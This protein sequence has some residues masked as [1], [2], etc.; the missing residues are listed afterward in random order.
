MHRPGPRRS[1]S[2]AA[3][4]APSRSSAPPR[5]HRLVRV[6]VVPA[7]WLLSQRSDNRIFQEMNTARVVREVLADAGDLPRRRALVVDPSLDALP[8]REYCVQYNES[9]LDFVRRLLEDE[10]VPFASRT[11][12]TAAR[13]WSSAG[14]EHGLG[15]RPPRS[16][17]RPRGSRR[18][19]VHPRRRPC[20]WFDE[21][22]R[23]GTTASVTVR[24]YDFT[25]PRATLDM[26][27]RHS[28][29]GR[30]LARYEYP[31]RATL[32]RYDEGARVYGTHNTAAPREGPRRGA[33]DPRA[34]RRGRGNVVTGMTPGA[35]ASTLSGHERPELD[36]RYLVTAVEHRGSDWS[37]VSPEVRRAQRAAPRD[38]RRRGAHHPR[39]REGAR[40]GNRFRHAPLDEHPASVPFRPARVTPRPVV[41]GP[42]T[43][44]VVGPAGEDI[45]TDPHG[46]VKVQFHW[47][48]EGARTTRARAGSA[49]RR[50]GRRRAGASSFI[51]RIGMEVVVSFLEGDPDRP[52]VT[53]CVYNGE[54]PTPYG[55]PE[56]KTKSTS[57]PRARRDRRLQRDALRRRRGPG[58]GVRP[59]R[60]RPWTPW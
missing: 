53:G 8:P 13:R 30:G 28:L 14:D 21:R 2:S 60:A 54:N 47:D 29:G 10:G 58:A 59:G 57:R 33:P 46:R 9:D 45:H 56:T 42:Q 11:T 1:A 27:G 22:A 24:D 55:L 6:E 20:P 41:E 36:R 15:P 5:S 48:R 34:P 3:W 32:A 39:R 26:T 51:P 50:D 49:W 4:C 38:A 12:A 43:A 37:R 35:R 52:L 18:G 7:L 40:Y 44:R 25:R 23:A 31:A 17:A 19:G 16:T